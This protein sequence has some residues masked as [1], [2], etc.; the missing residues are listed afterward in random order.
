MTTVARMV[1]QLVRI[2]TCHPYKVG[3]GSSPVR[4]AKGCHKGNLL[5]LYLPNRKRY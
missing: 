5:R 3:T 1:V 2:H 4:S